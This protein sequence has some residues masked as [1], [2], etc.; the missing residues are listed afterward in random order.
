MVASVEDMNDLEEERDEFVKDGSTPYGILLN[1]NCPPNEK[2]GSFDLGN[3][4]CVPGTP[5]FIA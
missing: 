3:G 5:G 1:G 2:F 4:K